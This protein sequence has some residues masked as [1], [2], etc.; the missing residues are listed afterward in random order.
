MEIV[1]VATLLLSVTD[2]ALSV[3]VG[4]AGTVAG[5]VYVTEVPVM[6]LSVPQVAAEQPAASDQIAPAPVASSCSAAVKFSAAPGATTVKLRGAIETV[7]GLGL[8]VAVADFV[9]SAFEVA[10]TVTFAGDWKAG[11][12]V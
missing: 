9:G 5:A 8:T 4:G 3:I 7:T 6:L 10:R 12:A 1:T 11:G 2:V